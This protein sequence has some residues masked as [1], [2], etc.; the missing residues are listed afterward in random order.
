MPVDA[1]PDQR[2][3]TALDALRR[4]SVELAL[5]AASRLIHENLDQKKDREIVERYL[6]GLHD[7]GGA[8]A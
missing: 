1:V 5:A 4:E 7:E 3:G 8:Q 6:S 2:E